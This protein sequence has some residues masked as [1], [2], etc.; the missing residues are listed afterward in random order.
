[1]L[2]FSH[3][4]AIEGSSSSRQTSSRQGRWPPTQSTATELTSNTMKAQCKEIDTRAP[5]HS[6]NLQF[7]KKRTQS[8][9][10]ND[11]LVQIDW[12]HC[13][14]PQFSKI[15]TRVTIKRCQLLSCTAVRQ[16]QNCSSSF[17]C[18]ARQKMLVYCSAEEEQFRRWNCRAGEKEGKYPF[19]AT[20]ASVAAAAESK[21]DWQRENAHSGFKIRTRKRKKHAQN[22]EKLANWYV[23]RNLMQ[24]K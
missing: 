5:I 18:R 13:A 21:R 12:R 1:M 9:A 15:Q 2:P 7:V 4:Q 3:K 17:L 6:S 10:N 8:A 19:L 22:R 14:A 23:V 16:C 20:A 11:Y 24:L